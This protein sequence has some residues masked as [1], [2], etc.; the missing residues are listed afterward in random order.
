MAATFRG[1]RLLALLQ[2]RHTKWSVAI[3]AVAEL[4]AHFG[5]AHGSAAVHSHTAAAAIRA[6]G[7]RRAW[8]E[9][10]GLFRSVGASADLACYSATIRACGRA[11]RPVQ[12]LELLEEAEKVKCVTPEQRRGEDCKRSVDAGG[13]GRNDTVA[14][15]ALAAARSAAMSAVANVGDWQ[16]CLVLLASWQESHSRGHGPPPDV[17]ALSTTISACGRGR[18]SKL[19]LQILGSMRQAGFIPDVIAYSAAISACEEG[20]RWKKALELLASMKDAAVAPNVVSCS[21]AISACA[22]GQRWEQALQLLR[23]MDCYDVKPNIVSYSAAVSACTK[24]SA[25]QIALALWEERHHIGV[26][27]NRVGYGAA[28]GACAA[29]GQWEKAFMLLVE[30]QERRQKPDLISFTGV[31]S[32]CERAA[33]WECAVWLLGDMRRQRTRPDL[34]C[35]S[36]VKRA[37]HKARLGRRSHSLRLHS[38]NTRLQ[39]SLGIAVDA[40]IESE[41]DVAEVE[42]ISPV[43]VAQGAVLTTVDNSVGRCL[44]TD[45]KSAPDRIVKVD[46]GSMT[47]KTECL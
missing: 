43:P 21:A 27:P 7:R 36:I 35:A 34:V 31:L 29:G 22:K 13:N 38:R 12:A 24:G 45:D 17:M 26:S 4:S 41:M 44:P 40:E 23:T 14:A 8:A 20:R 1:E 19:A 33:S 47:K 30:M 9:A 2:N 15:T 10:L 16:R 39:A 5:S 25:W 42:T 32:A 3:E 6:L 28:L 11:G 37:R 46:I 18:Q